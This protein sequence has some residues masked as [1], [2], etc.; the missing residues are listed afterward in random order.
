[1]DFR[2]DTYNQNLEK[3][4]ICFITYNKTPNHN[5]NLKTKFQ[6]NNLTKR[7]IDYFIHD[8]ISTFKI[9]QEINLFFTNKELDYYKTSLEKIYYKYLDKKK[10]KYYSDIINELLPFVFKFEDLYKLSINY[11]LIYYFKQDLIDSNNNLQ[12]ILNLF[13]QIIKKVFHPDPS[14]RFNF[15]QINLLI[16]FIIKTINTIDIHDNTDKTI[17]FYNELNNF[18]TIKKLPKNIIFQKDFAFID[19]NS[20]LNESVINFIKK[21]NIKI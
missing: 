16:K 7:D 15:H 17:T 6:E 19:F 11:L 8:A 3:R 13:I 2:E 12:L 10:F 21:S 5:I 20:V 4:F 14:M 18:I 9:N 1:M